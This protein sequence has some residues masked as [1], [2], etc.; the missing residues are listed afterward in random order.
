MNMMMYLVLILG[1]LFISHSFG[2]FTSENVVFQKTNEVFI[3]DAHWSVTFVHDLKPF[4][5][6]IN[7][8]SNDLVRT[9]EIVVAITNFYKSSNLTGYVE[10]F[11]S[12]HV[13]IDLL[14]DTYK[15]VYDNFDEYRTLSSSDP[16]NKRSLLPVI[17]QLMSTLFGTVSES[18]LENINRNI[19]ALASNQEQIIHDLDV[20]LSVLNLTRMQVAENRRSIMDLIIVIQKLDK[21][22]RQLEQTF[23]QKF[24]RLE[25]FIHTYLQFQ[26]IFDEIKF[27]IQDAI[28][29]LENL[30]SELN[31]LSMH[32][33]STSTISPKNL[34][35]LLIEVET[36]LPINFELPRDPRRD[37]WYFYKTLTCI[38]YLEDN[39]IR[40]VLK[41]PLINTKEE[42]EVYKIYNLPIPIQHKNMNTNQTD[43]LLKYG[44]EAEMLMVSK[45]RSKFSLLSE[46][47]FQM[48]NGYHFQFCN[49]ETAFY[50]T[51]INKFCVM[52]LFLQNVGDIKT[53]CKQMIVL[54]Y[55]LP[56]TKYLSCG[57]WIVVTNKPLTF[58]VNCQSYYPKLDDIKIAPPFG[59]IKLN[60]TC[61]AS[62]KYLQL[63]EYFGK[64][65]K[66]E[67]SDPLQAL[68][69]LHNISQ[70]SIWNDS[71]T[72]F[73]KLESVK[74]PSHLTGLKEIPMQS[75]LRETRAYKTINLEHNKTK[76][77]WTT[78]TAIIIVSVIIILIIVWLI[79][80]KSKCYF[81]QIIGKQLA[82]VHDLGR[83]D[84]KQSPPRGED[85]EMSALI[86]RR[87]VD[88]D[89]E[90]Q[91]NTFRRTDATLAWCHK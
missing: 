42:Y 84:V 52:A 73:E 18:D 62:N 38:I 76:N 36:K 15:S 51:N 1:S 55:K 34:K 41:I 57:L 26:M 37:I 77:S 67:M 71:K 16:R 44:L 3:N 31:M 59:I 24:V 53:Y 58:T 10:T 85:I 32:H 68:L 22:I 82:N 6:L 61:K 75:F 4:Q 87:N 86:E 54:N 69:K 25:Q 29:Y 7:E 9:N 46:N 83:V 80:R 48:C 5:N 17:G 63:P 79:V 70:F 78:V 81:G 45:D 91:Q 39:E 72:E 21:K 66:F 88:N 64:Y 50:Q 20:S 28:F 43:I 27:T 8:I 56:T 33:L 65:S 60:N 23:E 11:K 74:M 49:P 30:K 90:G 14:T 89:S 35:A 47:T 12:L 2:L 19:K 40:I 13:E